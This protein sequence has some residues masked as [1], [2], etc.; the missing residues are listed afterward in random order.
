MNRLQFLPHEDFDTLPPH[1]R[2]VTAPSW[3]GAGCDVLFAPN[4]RELY[5]EPQR[6]Q[7]APYRP[8]WPT[9]WK[10]EFR[11]GFFIGVS[12]VVMKLF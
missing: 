6:L 4:E 5:P 3:E 1:L 12:T 11:P 7:G 8:N 10:G 9:C 2:G